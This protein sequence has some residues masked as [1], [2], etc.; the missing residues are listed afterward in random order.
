MSTTATS[1]TAPAAGISGLLGVVEDHVERAAVLGDAGDRPADLVLR[2]EQ[3]RGSVEVARS[4]G[5]CSRDPLH[6][7]DDAL[8]RGEHAVE[9]VDHDRQ[10]RDEEEDVPD[11]PE[12]H[13]GLLSATT[14][15]LEAMP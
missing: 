5:G 9:Q 13:R 12:R 14:A 11:P 2:R 15:A 6:A 4:G 10:D 1:I 8:R 3:Q 7:R